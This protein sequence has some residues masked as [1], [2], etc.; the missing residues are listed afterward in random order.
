MKDEWER[1]WKEEV[2]AQSTDYCRFLLEGLR[3][4]HEH[5]QSVDVPAKIRTEQL[6][7]T[8]LGYR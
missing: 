8:P 3:K 4:S 7:V 6:L 2:V 1:I 5:P